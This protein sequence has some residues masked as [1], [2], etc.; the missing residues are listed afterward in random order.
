MAKIL[1]SIEDKLLRRIDRAAKALGM[2][3]SGY[4]ARLAARDV[5]ERGGPGRR[6]GPRRALANLDRLFE[7]VPGDAGSTQAIRRQRDER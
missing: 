2:T 1:V 6:T 3:R 7:G 5:D 4:L